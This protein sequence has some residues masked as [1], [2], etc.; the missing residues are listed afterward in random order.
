M[1]SALKG[2]NFYQRTKDSC[3]GGNENQH[4]LFMRSLNPK[5][6]TQKLAQEELEFITQ[7]AY[8]P[9]SL[10]GYLVLPWLKVFQDL[11]FKSY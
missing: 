2:E 9:L 4:D 10:E 3:N 5:L 1:N 11:I 7:A 6:N 8:P